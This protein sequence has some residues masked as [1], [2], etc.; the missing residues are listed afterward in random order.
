MQEDRAASGFRPSGRVIETDIDVIAADTVGQLR[1]ISV[2]AAYIRS[3]HACVA[4]GEIKTDIVR[5]VVHTIGVTYDRGCRLGCRFVRRT[6]CGNYRSREDKE[7]NKLS[8]IACV[9]EIRRE[10]T[11]FLRYEQEKSLDVFA[12]QDYQKGQKNYRGYL[13]MIC[14]N[15]ER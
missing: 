9:F 11:A 10:I 13:P 3:I 2:S 1:D 7:I 12:H 6:S 8:H 5:S 14:S 15:C 4:V